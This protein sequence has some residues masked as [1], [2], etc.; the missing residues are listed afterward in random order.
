MSAAVWHETQW[1]DT[2]GEGPASRGGGP[3]SRPQDARRDEPP[4]ETEAAVT[5][6]AAVGVL[7][8]LAG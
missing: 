4:R 3:R 8:D 2:G 5:A 7:A 1:T 6:G